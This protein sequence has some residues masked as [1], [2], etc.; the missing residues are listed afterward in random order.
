[1][2]KKE[3]RQEETA[4]F[5][6]TELSAVRDMEQAAKEELKKY[7]KKEDILA[8]SRSCLESVME[9][10]RG[11]SEDEGEE[12]GSK[13][14]EEDGEMDWEYVQECLEDTVIPEAAVLSKEDKE[15][16]ACWIVWKIY[17]QETCLNWWCRMTRRS[18]KKRYPP[19]RL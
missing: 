8:E 13:Q 5:F 6:N 1:M 12:N 9:L 16:A 3:A 7:R 11:E 2:E 15:S 19:H 18:P 4:S 10:L 14:D 17:F